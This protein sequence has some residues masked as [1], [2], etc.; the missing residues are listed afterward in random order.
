VEHGPDRDARAPELPRQRHDHNVRSTL[1]SPSPPPSLIT[2][3]HGPFASPR[4]RSAQMADWALWSRRSC[5]VTACAN[6]R[7]GAGAHRTRQKAALSHLA[8]DAP[9]RH[10]S[11]M[12]RVRSPRVDCVP[13]LPRSGSI[14][15]PMSLSTGEPLAGVRPRPRPRSLPR[16]AAAGA[17]RR[18]GK[19]PLSPSAEIESRLRREPPLD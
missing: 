15:G 13:R 18:R 10:P 1:S 19:K 9:L 4:G 11:R 7:D 6:A 16:A 5:A 17:G 14:P 3:A 2:I 8:S 12:A